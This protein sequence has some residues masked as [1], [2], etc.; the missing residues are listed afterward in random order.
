M[1]DGTGTAERLT[2]S[3]N[4]QAAV[5]FSPDGTRLVFEELFPDTGVDLVMMSVEDERATEVLLRTEFDERNAEISPDGSWLA[6]ESNASGQFEVYVRPFPDVDS[7]RW[8]VSTEGGVTPL[9]APDGRELFYVAPVG[10]PMMAVTVQT[11]ATFA[12]GNPEVLFKENYHFG[13]LGRN[14]DIA[15]DGRRFL[16]IKAGGGS[17][18]TGAAPSIIVVENWLDELAQRVPAP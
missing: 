9:R 17:D 3:S 8:Q 7:G 6:Y 15:P 18:G 11:D 5:S 10:G 2:E 1:A 4:L 12:L 16:M 14:Y 13:G